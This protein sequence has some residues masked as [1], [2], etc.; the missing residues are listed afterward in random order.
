M[1]TH[2][3]LSFDADEIRGFVGAMI[4][5]AQNHREAE[6][7]TAIVN[8]DATIRRL[9]NIAPPDGLVLEKV[10]YDPEPDWLTL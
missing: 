7:F 2:T 8:G 9:G 6:E 5:V 10:T 1:G 3:L 4:H